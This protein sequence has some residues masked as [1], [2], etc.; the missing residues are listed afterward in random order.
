[1]RLA[2]ELVEG[3]EQMALHRMWM[4]V[5]IIQTVKSLNRTKFE[6]GR[7]L[8]F[9]PECFSWDIDPLPSAFLVLRPS[10]SELNN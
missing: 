2:F 5:N 1:M 10:E 6:K 4:W 3:V 9:L 7:I 8:P